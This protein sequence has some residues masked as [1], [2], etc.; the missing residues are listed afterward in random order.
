MMMFAKIPS[1]YTGDDACQNDSYLAG[2]GLLARP[3]QGGRPVQR[4]ADDMTLSM[5]LSTLLLLGRL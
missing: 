3:G 2:M 4:L 5:V 1:E